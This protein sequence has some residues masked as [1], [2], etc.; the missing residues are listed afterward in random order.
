MQRVWCWRC[1]CGLPMLDEQEYAE[2]A[3]LFRDGMQSRKGRRAQT[4][5]TQAYWKGLGPN[6]R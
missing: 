3:T 4:D 5:I 2:I 1:K 6:C